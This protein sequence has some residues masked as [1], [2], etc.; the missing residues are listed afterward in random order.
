LPFIAAGLA[1]PDSIAFADRAIGP[2]LRSLALALGESRG[3]K[4]R[5]GNMVEYGPDSARF[6]AAAQP[7]RT[8][9]G[10]L[11]DSLH[12]SRGAGD[13]A[14]AADLAA[15]A[16]A[17]WGELRGV[18][19]EMAQPEIVRRLLARWFDAVL[20]DSSRHANH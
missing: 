19:L 6:R 3:V 2:L 10:Y 17:V 15:R 1:P 14:G 16:V 9:L 7:L 11:A 8:R 5:L 13:S 4:P 18:Y 20:A 12:Q